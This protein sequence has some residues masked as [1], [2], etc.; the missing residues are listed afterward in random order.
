[1]REMEQMENAMWCDFAKAF[2]VEVLRVDP[3]SIPAWEVREVKV[4]GAS[5]ENGW[6]ATLFLF[7]GSLSGECCVWLATGSAQ[8][9][10]GK[11][12]GE[13][14]KQELL[15]AAMAASA[16]RF[17]EVRASVY[18]DFAV[19]GRRAEEKSV[20]LKHTVRV[21]LMN[22]GSL[23]VVYVSLSGELASAIV[24]SYSQPVNEERSSNA[25]LHP[26]NLDA[27]MD[28]ELEVALRFGQRELTLREVLELTSGSVVELDRQVEEPIELILDGKVVA[29]GEAV[30]IDGNY[31]LRVTEV[32]APFAAAR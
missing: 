6:I 14:E 22:A 2:A 9:L 8:V 3:A 31:G 15:F 25:A 30:V 11:C 4:V 23:L 10:A 13:G 1:M 28:V 20:G 32:A 5:P 17:A 27:V 12:P 18:G 19:E 24:G 21:T 26:Q 16:A 29:R 7:N